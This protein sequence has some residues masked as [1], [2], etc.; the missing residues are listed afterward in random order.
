MNA[1]CTSS[2]SLHSLS[3]FFSSNVALIFAFSQPSLSLCYH[4]LTMLFCTSNQTLINSPLHLC[5]QTPYV[6]T[7]DCTICFGYTTLPRSLPSH[8]IIRWEPEGHQLFLKWYKLTPLWLWTDKIHILTHHLTSLHSD[9]VTM[10]P[11][12]PA[13]E[14]QTSCA[15]RPL[16]SLVWRETCLSTH[17]TCLWPT[18]MQP[19]YFRQSLTLPP[20]LHCFLM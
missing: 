15:N 14:K 7:L 11:P 12:P 18:T 2:S 6:V 10:F 13:I 3:S 16:G 4:I 17:P 1:F 8:Q 20:A 19:G 5:L 9:C